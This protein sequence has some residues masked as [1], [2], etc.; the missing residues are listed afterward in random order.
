MIVAVAATAHVGAVIEVSERSEG[1]WPG[2]V[3]P[4]RTPTCCWV[5]RYRGVVDGRPGHWQPTRALAERELRQ[6][7]A[8]T[9]AGL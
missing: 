3:Y 2:W 5:T 8:Q 7:L 9:R 1:T 6:L 4:R